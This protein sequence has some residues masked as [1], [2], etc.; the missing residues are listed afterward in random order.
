[1]NYCHAG[2]PPR[3]SERHPPRG[4]SDIDRFPRIELKRSHAR[5]K[6]EV[7]L[8]AFAVEDARM[9]KPRADLNK[10]RDHNP[11]IFTNPDEAFGHSL[12]R[13]A[14]F[15]SSCTQSQEPFFASSYHN[16]TARPPQV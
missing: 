1:M 2:N 5:M 13:K 7:K 8:S 12:G 3:D 15:G 6:I 16:E 9:P 10:W 4:S 11:R 14:I